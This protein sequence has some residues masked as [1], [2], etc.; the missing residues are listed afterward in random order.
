MFGKKTNINMEHYSLK[1]RLEDDADLTEAQKAKLRKVYD[2]IK[3]KGVVQHSFEILGFENLDE[4]TPFSYK[5]CIV[6][7][8]KNIDTVNNKTEADHLERLFYFFDEL[9]C[10][11]FDKLVRIR[12]ILNWVDITDFDKEI[13]K[14]LKDL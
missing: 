4:V 2:T 13:D 5:Q 11:D 14:L 12:Y 9:D 7:L 1:D 3:M 10:S 6:S 8:L